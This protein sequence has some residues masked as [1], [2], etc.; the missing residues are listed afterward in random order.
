MRKL[1]LFVFL[2]GS[3]NILSGCLTLSDH[4]PQKRPDF[5]KPT[6]PNPAA[7]PSACKGCACS[8]VSSTAPV[9]S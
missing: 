3:I 1:I 7:S 9:R 4:P 5:S 8:A 6:H 2:A